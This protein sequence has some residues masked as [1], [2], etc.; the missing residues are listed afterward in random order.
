MTNK[1]SVI[2]LFSGSGG[3]AWGFKKA[4]F[5]LRVAVEIDRVASA[6]FKENFPET[7][8]INEDIS[9]IN[10]K[11]LLKSANIKQ[12]EKDTLVILACPPCQ[13]FSTARRKEQRLMD[14]RNILI[15][16]FVRLVGEIRPIAFVLENVPGLL[17]GM[18]R[19]VFE[20]A[21]GKLS[22]M[23]YTMT[24]PKILETADY[25]IP[26]KRRRLVIMG[27]RSNKLKLALPEPTHQSPVS[28]SN[29]L[30]FWKTVRDVIS[31]L[32][33]IPTGAKNTVDELHVSANLSETNLER[34]KH[35]PENGGGR[36]SWPDYLKLKCHESVSGY[37]DVYGR[38]FWD[39][40]SPTITGGCVMLSK[41]RFGH[42]EQNRAISLREAA[43]LQTFPDEFKF[44]GNFG[45]IASQIGNAV[46]PLL[47]QRLAESLRRSLNDYFKTTEKPKERKSVRVGFFDHFVYP[48]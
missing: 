35:T 18:G 10:G 48:Q 32:P 11:L 27:T 38:M 37:Y 4:G 43:R 19:N 15:M 30:A 13:G 28:R 29:H 8:V 5:A 47:A 31:D 26:Q 34:L 24:D 9:K 17:K 1:Y 40:P 3:S 20:M 21:T 14:P 41:G 42:P 46:P 16:E 2:D 22:E 6:S 39:S 45:E 33:P 7:T 25:G 36:K 44:I 23:G 12:H